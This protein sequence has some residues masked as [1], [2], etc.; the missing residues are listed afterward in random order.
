MTSGRSRTPSP[1][2]PCSPSWKSGIAPLFQQHTAAP[3]NYEIIIEADQEVYLQTIHC[4]RGCRHDE[5]VRVSP[6]D[7]LLSSGPKLAIG[8]GALGFW[9]ALTME[10]PNTWQQRCWVH[11]TANVWGGGLIPS[12]D[13]NLVYR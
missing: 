3:A 12:Y 8:D 9:K 1:A 2:P 4:F 6:R 13:Q 10:F 5:E 11:K 7:F